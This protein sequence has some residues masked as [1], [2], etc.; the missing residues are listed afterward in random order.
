M[1]MRSPI[2]E[3][4]SEA[5]WKVCRL[6]MRGAFEDSNPLPKVEDPEGI[7]AFL[8]R[9]FE[10][11]LIGGQNQDQPIQNA[12]RALASVSSPTSIEAL[13]RFD[14]T[15]RLF[16]RGI[17]HALQPDRLSK[18]REAAILF[19]PRIGNKWFHP[20]ALIMGSTEMKSFCIDWA[21][22]VDCLEQ[23]PAVKEAA[24]TIL[25]GMINSPRW[26]PHI[27]SEKWGLLEHFMLI[28]GD[29]HSLRVAINDSDLMDGVRNV[30][31]PRAV[32]LWAEILWF[33]YGELI[34][35]VREQ[36]ETVTKEI[37]QNERGKSQVD[38][39]LSNA[40]SELRKVEDALGGCTL[41]PT[42]PVVIVLRERIGML[43][44]ASQ[45]L[46]A[47]RLGGTPSRVPGVV[48]ADG[49]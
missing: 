8:D 32:V 1:V 27:V 12:L 46:E 2:P 42:D 21:S 3:T 10:L 11:A 36:L 30:D 5:K 18:L 37:A 22:A 25:L 26:R 39:F 41:P 44:R 34:P 19:L 23:T 29:L 28:P 14:P 16:V 20:C 40:N 4:H 31:N 49:A 7:L 33:K 48:T 43:Q 15:G 6:T 24:L 45:A 13:N 38:K 17:R 47:I 9:H 35:M